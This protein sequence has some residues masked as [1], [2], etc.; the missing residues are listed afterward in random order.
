MSAFL[1]SDR[2][3][4]TLV[5]YANRNRL[6]VY[7]DGR[8]HSCTDLD[9]LA[10]K[11]QAENIRSLNSR[12]GD[13]ELDPT[14]SH[15]LWGSYTMEPVQILKACDCF[16]YQACESDDYNDTFSAALIQRI[17]NNAI[18]KLPGYDEAIWGVPGE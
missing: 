7:H 11:L 16:D 4:N 14:I 13:E 15:E 12:Y 1:C 6:T 9:G 17:R 10:K 3:I 5:N 18:T 2:H 8:T